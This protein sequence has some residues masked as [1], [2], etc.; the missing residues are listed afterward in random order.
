MILKSG[1]L[2]KEVIK[3]LNDAKQL[4]HD[5]NSHMRDKV[6]M[7]ELFLK[8]NKGKNI[9]LILENSEVEGILDNIN[10]YRVEIVSDGEKRYYNKNMLT[11]FYAKS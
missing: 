6:D 1:D 5:L 2:Y 10:R 3:V 8:E 4:S 7:E 9:A 11:G